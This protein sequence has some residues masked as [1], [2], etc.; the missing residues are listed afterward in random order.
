MSA[1]LV[2]LVEK[3]REIDDEFGRIGMGMGGF[4]IDF[5]SRRNMNLMGATQT[6]LKKLLQINKKCL[7]Q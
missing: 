7:K 5:G 2:Y 4:G 6:E 1:S 3:K